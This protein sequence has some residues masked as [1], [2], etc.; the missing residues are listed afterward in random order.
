MSH[1]QQIQTL[2]IGRASD[3]INR[4]FSRLKPI[5]TYLANQLRDIGIENA[6]VL[7]DGENS[8]QK[9]MKFLNNGDI[10]LV[11]E[12][13]FSAAEYQKHCG[14]Y[15]LVMVQR[16]G[17]IEYQSYIFVR[18]ESTVDKLTDLLGKIIAF[19]DPTSTSSYRWPANS[20]AE[21]NI[22]LF[23]TTNNAAIPS[24]SVGYLFAGS[25]INISSYVFYG[26]AD[27][28]ALSSADW[29]NPEEN[30]ESYKKNFRI[31]HTTKPIPRMVVMARKDLPSLLASRL[32][33]EML[34][35]HETHEGKTALQPYSIDRFWPVTH[36]QRELI[37][38][39]AK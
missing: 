34:K 16:E 4:N 9:I 5:V 12:S 26:K 33:D 36:N 35:M 6:K 19:E 13:P 17:L 2:T 10:D 25:E 28:G 38:R 27:A 32:R 14:A 3:N 29:I 22:P 21:K 37:T 11:F 23:L 8:N 24:D 31:I 30:P 20:F 39:L 15:P 1:A 7:L 18:K